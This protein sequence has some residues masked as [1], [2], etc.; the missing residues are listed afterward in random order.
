MDL[1]RSQDETPE[2]VRSVITSLRA[3]DVI[4]EFQSGAVSFLGISPQAGEAAGP[5]TASELRPVDPEMHRDPRFAD[6]E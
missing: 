4:Y 2:P 6:G 3:L 1:V 5:R